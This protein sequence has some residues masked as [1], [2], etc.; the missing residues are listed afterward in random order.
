MPNIRLDINLRS[1]VAM[2]CNLPQRSIKNPLKAYC[3]S[4][5][6]LLGCIL[7]FL[8][9]L[10]SK[11][12]EFLNFQVEVPLY[13]LDDPYRTMDDAM[14]LFRNDNADQ[15]S[16]KPTLQLERSTSSY[17]AEQGRVSTARITLLYVSESEP[18]YDAAKLTK[19]YEFEQTFLQ[20]TFFQ[21]NCLLD[22]SAQALLA[23]KTKNVSLV[24]AL[25]S[26]RDNFP[27][28][29]RP[30]T[31][32]QACDPA[33][34]VPCSSPLAQPMG[35]FDC[36]LVNA[37]CDSSSLAISQSFIDLKLE[38]AWAMPA[39]STASEFYNGASASFGSR[40]EE[41]FSAAAL[42]GMRAFKTTFNLGF[43]LRGYESVDDRMEE[44]RLALE[45]IILK[46]LEPLFSAQHND[47]KSDI[48]VLM[49]YDGPGLRWGFIRQQI[50][51]DMT[52]AIFSFLFVM[53]YI[54]LLKKSFFLSLHAMGMIVLSLFP[55]YF[56]YAILGNS[57]FGTFNL[58]CVFIIL[59]IGAD[60]VFVFIDTW[61]QSYMAI[62]N[63]GQDYK[64]RKIKQMEYTLSRAGTAMLVTSL[65]TMVSF[66]ST[67]RSSFPGIATFGIWA[68]GLVFTNYILVMTYY[69]TV[70][71]LNNQYI[72]K[73]AG[74]T[75]PWCFACRNDPA[76]ASSAQIAPAAKAQTQEGL[77]SA[78][79]DA[80]ATG[81]RNARRRRAS[82][83][84]NTTDIMQESQSKIVNFF[85][86]VH[87]PFV[88]RFRIPILVFCVALF[89]FFGYFAAQLEIDPESPKILADHM[90]A[91]A[92]SPA[93]Q[94]NFQK[95]LLGVSAVHGFQETPID[96]TGVDKT[97][98]SDKGTINVVEGGLDGPALG[99]CVRAI[100]QKFDVENEQLGL[101]G[102]G[103]DKISCWAQDLYETQFAFFESNPEAA[104]TS[105]TSGL[106][107]TLWQQK[108]FNFLTSPAGFKHKHNLLTQTQES[109]GLPPTINIVMSSVDVKINRPYT[110]P[111]LDGLELM[112]QWDAQLQQW[113]SVDLQECA[114]LSQGGIDKPQVPV[115]LAVPSLGQRFGTSKTLAREAFSGI[116]ISLAL[117]YIVLTIFSRNYLVAAAATLSICCIVVCVIGIMVLL[118]LKLGMLE[119][120]NLVFTPGLSVDFVAHLAEGYIAAG[121][122]PNGHTDRRGRMHTSL[123]HVGI[124]IFSGCFSTLGACVFLFFPMIL[125][126]VQFGTFIFVTVGTSFFVAAFFF[127]ALMMTIGPQGNSGA[128]TLNR[129]SK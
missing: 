72:S 52:F 73:Y 116:I 28:C 50:P 90:N 122:G 70:V 31:Q 82:V 112:E 101:A 29:T 105:A 98:P 42:E 51:K 12:T 65:T 120:I 16:L 85:R 109:E 107:N 113:Y 97:I 60:D 1:I 25:N 121:H 86:D 68:A 99:K 18:I 6:A 74:P 32:L 93:Y 96:R 64:E 76:E 57:Y 21:E 88:F 20:S 38:Q 67:A 119:S 59:G 8:G 2:W 114:A 117:A 34:G 92:Y 63:T 23:E 62:P 58:L 47:F 128:L 106:N 30:T 37:S 103:Q 79:K 10:K 69:P 83:Q 44:Q 84:D 24:A 14:F 71:A 129:C 111:F 13:D 87:S 15:N 9:L 124:S 54:T 19:L 89:A 43:P 39:Q 46:E 100:C 55:A 56:I 102:S 40:S 127:S 48:G 41:A 78:D 35:L 115:H 7:L 17:T 26:D 125:F 75:T 33:L 5:G 36:P 22:W 126:F 66:L 123:T 80:S 77:G 94:E 53:V 110:M 11:G 81:S 108:L 104:W 4:C 91:G 118:G 61:N 49:W 45:E 27:S 95:I 3:T